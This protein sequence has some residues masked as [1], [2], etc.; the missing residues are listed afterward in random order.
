MMHGGGGPFGSLSCCGE[1]DCTNTCA[2]SALKRCHSSLT[3]LN[4]FQ[5]LRG[6]GIRFSFPGFLC[7]FICK[8]RAGSFC[9]LNE[10]HPRD[11]SIILL[12]LRW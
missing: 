11:T 1:K 2:S 4:L 9:V 8:W 3:W 7:F 10:L 12:M 5:S 6:Y